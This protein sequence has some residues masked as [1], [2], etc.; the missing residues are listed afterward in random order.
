MREG[1]YTHFQVYRNNNNNKNTIKKKLNTNWNSSHVCNRIQPCHGI[2]DWTSLVGP[3]FFLNSVCV[4]VCV[5]EREQRAEREEKK[6]FACQILPSVIV[7]IILGTALF[8]GS[9]WKTSLIKSIPFLFFVFSVIMW[10]AT[11]KTNT[12]RKR[13]RKTWEKSFSEWQR[14]FSYVLYIIYLY[15][16]IKKT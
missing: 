5:C 1:N 6:E 2:W 8:A 16:Y 10:S 15:L 14:K 4:C 11:R 3:T 7:I 13:K 12:T 9:C